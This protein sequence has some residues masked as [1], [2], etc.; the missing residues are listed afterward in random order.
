ML[1]DRDRQ[2]LEHIV[3]YCDEIRGTIEMFGDTLQTLMAN[4]VYKNAVSMCVFQIGELTTHFSREFLAA[5]TEIP[6]AKIKKMRN[7]AAHHY[8]K[9]SINILHETIINDIPKLKE[10]CQKLLLG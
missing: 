2:V 6:W 9:F 5:N 10:Y 8:K 3:E 4:H 1:R 7:I